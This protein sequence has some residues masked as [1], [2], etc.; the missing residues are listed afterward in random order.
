MR[1]KVVVD[2]GL[3]LNRHARE[4]GGGDYQLWIDVH[5][6]NSNN[7]RGRAEQ[8]PRHAHELCS[9]IQNMLDGVLN[10]KDRDAF[11][12]VL[13][14]FRMHPEC[15]VTMIKE[16][17]LIKVTKSLPFE[18]EML[19]KVLKRG[20]VGVGVNGAGFHHQQAQSSM[21]THIR[22]GT[23]VQSSD[24]SDATSDDITP[25]SQQEGG[26]TRSSRRKKLVR[27]FRRIGSASAPPKQTRKQ[28]R[29]SEWETECGVTNYGT[30]CG[31]L[32][33]SQSLDYSTCEVV[34]GNP[35]C[36]D[37]IA[38]NWLE[39]GENSCPRQSDYYQGVVEAVD[40]SHITFRDP[41][42]GSTYRE[43]LANFNDVR[44]V[45]KG[46]NGG[47]DGNGTG[48]RFDASNGNGG[49]SRS[50]DGSFPIPAGKE[51]DG[52]G[53]QAMLRDLKKKRLS[54]VLGEPNVDTG[55]TAPGVETSIEGYRERT[56]EVLPTPEHKAKQAQKVVPRAKMTKK[57][58][59]KCMQFS[60]GSVL[61][62]LGNKEDKTGSTS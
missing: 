25:V 13:D 12:L 45:R 49:G 11:T 8:A 43:N 26:G 59:T 27:H 56:P 52:K 21:G 4:L 41:F 10:T 53:Y 20:T 50:G 34:K 9:S 51:K 61:K 1:V 14:G 7:S 38:Y 19:S 24:P 3:I 62:N 33:T 48:N 42:D 17:D 23:P 6:N 18:K 57:E 58:K 29:A 15:P 31:G 39:M 32:G 46:S 35:S 44:L 28:K 36:G 37:T 47:T 5:L 30:D 60:V 55:G 40:G 2:A 16:D 54:D 22:F